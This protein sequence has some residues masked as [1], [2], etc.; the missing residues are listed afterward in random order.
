MIDYK[1]RWKNYIHN[2]RK[3]EIEI[4]QKYLNGKIFHKGLE[5]GAGDGYQ[6]EFLL[7]NVKH[8]VCTELNKERLIQVN[9]NIEY[10]V[11]DAELLTKFFNRNEF[12]FVYSSNLLEHLNNIEDTIIGIKEILKDEGVVIH[13]LPNSKWAICHIVLHYPAILFSLIQKILSRKKII[14]QN[15]SNIKGN[16]LKSEKETS[17]LLLRLLFPHPH[18]ISKNVF[19]EVFAFS[20]MKWK[21]IFLNNGFVITKI[22]HGSFSSGYGISSRFLRNLLYK[23]NISTSTIYILKKNLYG[24]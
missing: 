21:S 5:I 18:G 3:K 15:R 19:A 10:R 23:M 12:D 11:C 6:S 20:K 7:N 13:I 16:N 2:I 24:N 1:L 8:L 4:I 14:N 22:Q 17:S 9:K